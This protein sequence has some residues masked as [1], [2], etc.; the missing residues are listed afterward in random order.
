MGLGG[1]L[2]WT[3]LAREIR[4]KY[5]VRS[6]PVESY[7]SGVKL[8]KS[9]IFYNNPN[10]IQE[11]G[12]ELGVQIQLNNP[13]SNYCLRDTPEKAYHKTD[14]HIIETVCEPYGIQ[15]PQLRCEI[16]LDEEEKESVEKI[17]QS[18]PNVFLVIEPHSNFE[19]TVNRRYPLKKWQ[20]V[21]DELSKNVPVVQVGAS[22]KL[23][24]NNV[25]DLRG[26]TTFRTAGGIIGK[27]KGL[28]STEGGLIHL[29]TSFD[30]KSFV[31]LTGYQSRKMVEYPQ[32]VYIDISS[33][34]PCGMKID[35]PECSKDAI[36][37]DPQEIVDTI[38]RSLQ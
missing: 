15:N 3:A 34:G 29:A 11:F 31:I 24:L 4:S 25:I 16:Y 2:T 32:H 27:S 26:K 23:L 36:K 10:F 21:V 19:Y 17:K 13:A 38:Q 8:I 37:H 35:C 6:I 14:K 30:T 33:H 5:G 22:N 12:G 18:L 20:I 28:I 7:G 1:Y 9:S